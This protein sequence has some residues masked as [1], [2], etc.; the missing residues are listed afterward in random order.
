MSTVANG[1]S[2]NAR[3]QR[4]LKR[5]W[6]VQSNL[7]DEHVEAD[8]VEVTAAGGLV[9]YRYASRREAERTLLLTI[10]ANHWRRCQLESG[11]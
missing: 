10:A 5:R 2:A 6:L 3:E 9:F 11:D 1:S 7:G 8:E 4:A